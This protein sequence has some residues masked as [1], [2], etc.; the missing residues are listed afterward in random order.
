MTKQYDNYADLIMFTRA[1]GGTALRHVG[2]GTELVT[3]GNFSDGTTGWTDASTSPSIFT[4]SS[5]EG[6]LTVSSGQRARARNQ[7]SGLTVGRAYQ[8]KFDLGEVLEVNVGY[9]GDASV[10]YLSG[11][12]PTG[13]KTLNFVALGTTL[14]M[15]FHKAT[16]DGA[17][18]FDNISVKEVIFDRATDPLVLFNHPT[19][20]PRIEYDA[21]GNRKG[22]LIEEARTNF[23]PNSQGGTNV[24]SFSSGTGSFDLELENYSVAPDGTT[25]GLQLK[26]FMGATGGSYAGVTISAGTLSSQIRT[27]SFFG[28]SNTASNQT[29]QFRKSDGSVVTE[30]TITPEWQRFSI[31]QS[32]ASI[33]T[34]F[35]IWSP[36]NVSYTA[37]VDIS[38]WGMQLEEGSFPTSYISTSGSTAT[39]AADVA[40]IPTS[41]FG[42]NPDKGTVVVDFETQYGTVDTFPRIVELGNASTGINRV[43]VLITE[44][45]SQVR[46]TVL[47][48]NIAAAAFTVKTD[49]TPASGKL[50][51]A[52]ADNDFA[53]VADGGSVVTDTSGSFTTPSIPRD[54]LKIGGA[55]QTT[56]SNMGGHIKSIQYYPRRLTNAQLQELT[57]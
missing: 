39:R 3:N 18:T 26:W 54:I 27:F 43:S 31:S 10:D 14:Y 57:S 13:T 42:Y 12:Q 21:N 19:N 22:L 55:G 49:P 1:S 17:Y 24:S 35:Q 11:S 15:Q 46:C 41:A 32:V 40:S 45:I 33:N 51:F 16:V 8:L 34:G 52:F 44:S 29:M 2:Y 50:A 56:V 38:I 23:V 7:V 5:A 25:T 28:K 20:T 4:V 47:S 30:I 53:G 37:N 36:F 48:N 6:V 9:T